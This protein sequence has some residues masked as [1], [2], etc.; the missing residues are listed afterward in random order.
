MSRDR[1]LAATVAL[2]AVSLTLAVGFARVF[3]GWSFL[4]DLVAIA[5]AGH[6]AAHLLRRIGLPMLVVTPVTLL[7]LVHLTLWQQY[8]TTFGGPLSLLPTRATWDALTIELGLVRDQFPTATAPVSYGA[9]WAVL[10]AVAMIL[11]VVLS[12]LLVFGAEARAEALAP[13]G[14]AFIVV[15]ALGDGR[16]QLETMGVAVAVGTAAVIVLRAVQAP[17]GGPELRPADTR[18]SVVDRLV[19]AATGTALT[20]ALVAGLVGPRLPGADADALIDTR[21]RSGGITEVASPLVDIRARLVNQSDEVLF[22]VRSD[23]PAYWR[24]TALPEFDGTTFR[25]PTRPLQRIEGPLTMTRPGAPVNRQDIEIVGLGGRLLPAAA[26]PVEASGPGLRWNPD[27]STLVRVDDDMTTGEEFIVV[28]TSPA[29]QPSQLRTAGV[30]APPD[31]IHLELPDDFPRSVTETAIRLTAG[32]PSAYDAALALQTFFRTEFEYSLEVPAG[33]GASAIEVFLRQRIGYCEQFAASFAAMARA[34]GLP[35]RV[36]VGYTAG[37]ETPDGRRSVLG[38]HA[39]AW[40]EVWFDGVGWVPFEPTPGRGAPGTEQYTGVAPAQD[41]TP[42]TPS[43]DEAQDPE[44]ADPRTAPERPEPTDRLEDLDVADLFADPSAGQGS[45]PS[46]TRASPAG[47]GGALDVPRP[48]VI[49]G[50][51]GLLLVLPAM[52]RRLVR[53]RRSR[54]PAEERV[55]RAWRRATAAAL[56]AGAPGRE[57]M[58]TS[59]WA[60]AVASR[61]PGAARPMRSL[62]EVVDA[63]EYGPPGQVD[64]D[65]VGS[66]GDS[67]AWQ[68]TLWARQIDDMAADHLGIARR[69]VRYVAFWR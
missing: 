8:R 9:G 20:V 60:A 40:P 27:T 67:L 47:Q 32:A 57:S 56:A 35:S 4:P 31:P 26:D 58:T 1:Q 59:E 34:I 55:R 33:H 18:W 41:L 42:P 17:P 15:G 12:D 13:A 61:L 36:A 52:L 64:L 7:G 49:A 44:A 30:S 37:L 29:L 5:V 63:V 2:I 14:S 10:A 23:E 3:P 50:F 24:A 19:P 22:L 38:R 66:F 6:A 39:H 53:R 46:D 11:A 45:G 28:S 21:G 48:L 54:A 62:A 51:L 16:L 69:T 65:Q 43:T 25:L 68:C